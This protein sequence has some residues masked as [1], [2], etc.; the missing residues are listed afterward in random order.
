MLKRILSALVMCAIGIPALIF[1]GTFFYI[2][3][4]LLGIVA[5]YEIIDIKSDWNKYPKR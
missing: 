5:L 3:I 4:F 1:G 2:L